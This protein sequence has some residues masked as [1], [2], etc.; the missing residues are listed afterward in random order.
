MLA[1]IR[2]RRVKGTFQ[3]SFCSLF[4]SYSLNIR[5][6]MIVV[7]MTVFDIQEAKVSI[8]YSFIKEIVPMYI[9]KL[10]GLH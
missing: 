4:S 1:N 8:F 3:T 10:C 9:S 2:A 5:N 7:L 6:K